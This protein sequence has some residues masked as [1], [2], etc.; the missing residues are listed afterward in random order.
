MTPGPLAGGSVRGMNT[1]VLVLL[2]ACTGSTPNTIP[3]AAPP[4]ASPPVPV[5]EE[6]EDSEG[7]G[8]PVDGVTEEPVVGQ[9]FRLRLD[10]EETS[11]DEEA[12]TATFSPDSR[13]KSATYTRFMIDSAG[14]LE[15][16]GE[17]PTEPVEL[18]VEITGVSETAKRLDDDHLPQPMGGF[19]YIDWTATV[20]GLAE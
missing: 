9:Q 7:A 10:P 13:R 4:P 16:L 15:L 17:R 11:W 12:N 14:L 8:D 5:V 6:V 19:L 1:L 2:A 20:V 18:I 3:E